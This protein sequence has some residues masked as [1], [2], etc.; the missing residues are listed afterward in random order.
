VHLEHHREPQ[1]IRRLR[2]RS[3]RASSG[4]A[5]VEF[6]FVFPVIALLVFGF[7]DIGRAV[8]AY[9]TLTNAARQGARVAAVNQLD[10][11]SPPWQCDESRPVES[12]TTPHWTFRGCA[13]VSGGTIGVTPTDVGITY[14]APPGTSLTC[15]VGTELDIGCIA[16]VTVNAQFVPITPVAGAL[17]GS[18][19]M[20]STS[21]MPVER[22][23][24]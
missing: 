4:Q 20:S 5:L 11:S 24:P 1:V 18:I 12:V 17:I 13:M 10:P 19:A 6:A 14:S 3:G 15:D 9:S 23:F 7:I 22:L 16:S 21:Q 8:Y 2:Q